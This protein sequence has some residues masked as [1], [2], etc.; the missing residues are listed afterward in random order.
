MKLCILC[1]DENVN[2]AR[3]RI[4]ETGVFLEKA[5]TKLEGLALSFNGKDLKQHLNTPVSET[6]ELP[7]THWFCFINVSDETY[8]RMLDSQKYT[9]IEKEVPSVFLNKHNLKKIK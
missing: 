7:A 5:K 6:G 9:I 4:K 3:E 1:D 8:L 2:T